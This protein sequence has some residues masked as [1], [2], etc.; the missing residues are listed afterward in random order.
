MAVSQYPTRPDPAHSGEPAGPKHIKL[1]DVPPE[2]TG[3]SVRIFKDGGAS[4]GLNN[5]N[6]VLRWDFTYEG[7]FVSEAAMLDA[8]R[9][10]AQDQTGG[11]N[12]R[13]PRTHVLYTDCHYETYEIPNNEKYFMQD[14]HI[15]LIKRPTG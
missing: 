12:F 6:P 7:L 14:R 13:H 2:Y 5:P 10:E 1:I 11:F 15:V 8:H 3:Q 9:A 4:I